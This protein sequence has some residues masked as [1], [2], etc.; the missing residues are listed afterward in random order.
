MRIAFD[1]MGTLAGRNEVKVK[2]LFKALHDLGHE[3][4]VWSNSSSYA[5][6]MA[7]KLR[8]EGFKTEAM[9]KYTDTLEAEDLELFDVAIEDDTSQTWLAAKRL[10]FVHEI[11]DVDAIV[12]ML[13][14]T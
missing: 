13:T 14:K 12:R 5:Y 11:D 3:V 10:V 4:V 9:T 7:A 8:A 2:A 1:V 6:D